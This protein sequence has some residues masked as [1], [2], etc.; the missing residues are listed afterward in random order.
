MLPPTLFSRIFPLSFSTE[1]ASDNNSNA[2]QGKEAE[3]KTSH[4]LMGPSSRSR[5]VGEGMVFRSFGYCWDGNPQKWNGSA[6]NGKTFASHSHSHLLCTRL[7]KS[8]VGGT[9]RPVFH[10]KAQSEG[11][12]DV[13]VRVKFRKR[14]ASRHLP[15]PSASGMSEMIGYAGLRA[16]YSADV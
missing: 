11:C 2:A 15:D 7:R 8:S 1:P 10:T 5:L 3:K 14:S 16:N 12:V 9:T 6:R 13:R 4:L